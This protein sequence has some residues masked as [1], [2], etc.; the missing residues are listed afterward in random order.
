V[1]KTKLL[2][3]ISR[4]LTLQKQAGVVNSLSGT[5][6]FNIASE[7]LRRGWA[8]LFLVPELV[9]S[10]LRAFDAGRVAEMLG[11]K[12]VS[13]HHTLGASLLHRM[14]QALPH[15]VIGSDALFSSARANRHLGEANSGYLFPGI[16]CMVLEGPHSVSFYVED[17]EV[18]TRLIETHIWSS[19]VW[20]LTQPEN[21]S[22]P[23]DSNEL[24]RTLPAAP[25]RIDPFI[26]GGAYTPAEVASSLR[27]GAV[28][29]AGMTGVGKTR[30]ATEATRLL[31]GIQKVLVVPGASMLSGLDGDEGAAG[32]IVD[33][34]IGWGASSLVIDDCPHAQV[35]RL[36]DALDR[37]SAINVRVAVTIMSNRGTPKLPGLRPGRVERIFEMGA[38]TPEFVQ[39]LLQ[40]KGLAVD[41]WVREHLL[42][43]PIASIL[44]VYRHTEEGMTRDGALKLVLRQLELTAHDAEEVEA[45]A[46]A[47]S[48]SGGSPYMGHGAHSDIVERLEALSPRE[49]AELAALTKYLDGGEGATLVGEAD[50]RRAGMAGGF[51]VPTMRFSKA[52]PVS[53]VQRAHAIARRRKKNIGTALK[54]A[55]PAFILDPDGQS[56]DALVERGMVGEFDI[57]HDL[58]EV[59]LPSPATPVLR[60]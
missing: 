3:L 25:V 12:L 33:I 2:R 37:T 5:R 46:Y 41:D 40:Q 39:N 15:E 17:A 47:M 10:V 55:G 30:L 6:V 26:E 31:G 58:G 20:R 57:P 59:E 38:P 29:L 52:V 60:S 21:L 18:V 14:T 27:H 1:E 50:A 49:K 51:S 43:L 35:Y 44:A 9:V 54:K 56:T 32:R 19:P 4:I 7:A 53:A 16:P 24:I 13:V 48:Q 23:T 11:L 8:G 22:R 36:L 45:D 28:V 34:L 42:G